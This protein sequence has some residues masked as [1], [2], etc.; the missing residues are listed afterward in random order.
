MSRVKTTCR[1]P[2]KDKAECHKAANLAKSVLLTSENITEIG[3]DLPYGCISD[4]VTSGIHYIY[5]N[6]NGAA[7]SGDTKIRQICQDQ[8]QFEGN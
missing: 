7:I 3:G 6:Q 4:R 2:V 1:Y 5:W 8:D